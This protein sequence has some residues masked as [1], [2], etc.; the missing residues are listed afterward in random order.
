MHILL[1]VINDVVV[2]TRKKA[3]MS[4]ETGQCGL[5]KL[6]S[7]VWRTPVPQYGPKPNSLIVC[8][9]IQT[10][11]KMFPLFQDWWKSGERKLKHVRD[12]LKA[13]FCCA[14]KR[15]SVK[16]LSFILKIAN[17]SAKTSPAYVKEQDII[18]IIFFPPSASRHPCGT[19]KNQRHQR[20]WMDEK[21]SS[22]VGSARVKYRVRRPS[23]Y[24]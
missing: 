23:C 19:F 22:L 24:I 17:S 21:S 20:Q 9:W 18:L 6:G 11:G 13:V 16:R 14:R 8:A 12:F 5:T 7:V 4:N 3:E 1:T 2:V 10:E 15:K